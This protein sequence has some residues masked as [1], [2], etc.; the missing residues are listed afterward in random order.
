VASYDFSE[1]RVLAEL[2]AQAL[3]AKGVP[4]TVS[5]GLGTREIVQPALEQGRVDLVIDYLGTALDF[6]S[7][8]LKRAHASTASVYAA[9]QA[10]LKSRGITTVGYAQALDQNGFVVT[11][12]FANK[13]RI[14]RIS[15]LGPLAASLTLGGPPECVDRRYCLKGLQDT[16]GLQ[17]KAFRA[18]ST[19]AATA[20]ALASGEV[21]V[22]MVETTDARLAGGQLRPLADDLNLQPPENIVPLIRASV[23]QQFGDRLTSELRSLTARLRTQDLIDLNR[24]VEIEGKSISDAAAG[25]LSAHPG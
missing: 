25:W 18:L 11:T 23:A 6:V 7:P 1:N 14:S 5:S 24:A 22:G 16:Y 9:L 3:S 2:Y 8:G 17:F 19:R 12:E 20:T 15:E 21:D 4:V 10:A 13:H